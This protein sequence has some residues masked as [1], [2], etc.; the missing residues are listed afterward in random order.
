[1]VRKIAVIYIEEEMRQEK[2]LL[3]YVYIKII[4]LL[5]ETL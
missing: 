5:G 2:T 1:M 3:E 4:I